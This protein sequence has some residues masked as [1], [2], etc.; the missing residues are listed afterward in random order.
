MSSLAEPT[1]TQH[2]DAKEEKILAAAE[3]EI[4]QEQEEEAQ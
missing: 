3:A 2:S 1:Q 4:A